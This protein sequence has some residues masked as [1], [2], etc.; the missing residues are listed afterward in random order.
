MAHFLGASGAARFINAAEAATRTRRRRRFSRAPRTPTARSSTTRQGA[1]RSLKP[2]L[3]RAGSRH[4]VIGSATQI[5]AANP[6]DGSSKPQIAGARP[7]PAGA[8]PLFCRDVAATRGRRR[9]GRLSDRRCREV[10]RRSRRSP[11]P[12]ASLR[13]SRRQLRG[14]RPAA[15]AGGR[16]AYASA[17][18]SQ[19]PM[20]QFAVSARISAARS[21]RWC[22]SCGA[23][24]A[25]SVETAQCRS[26]RG[27][28][29]LRHRGPRLTRRS[30]CS[31]SCGPRCGVRPSAQAA[32][33]RHAW[34]FNNSAIF[35]KIY[36]ERVC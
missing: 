7:R 5:A 14:P 35:P 16:A 17:A 31:S 22:A 30:T 28:D 9:I 29:H 11:P 15:F 18:A 25:T 12:S 24:A 32:A 21:R 13:R 8:R 26:R 33:R 6:A 27:D 3:C 36:G 20:F 23:T 19:A 2:G 4:D 10:R 34:R 1:A